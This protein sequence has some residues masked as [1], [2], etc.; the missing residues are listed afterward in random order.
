MLLLSTLLPGFLF[1]RLS[2]TLL[3]ENKRVKLLFCAPTLAEMSVGEGAKRVL[4]KRTHDG[5]VSS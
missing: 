1:T 5:T 2:R 4:W 3:L